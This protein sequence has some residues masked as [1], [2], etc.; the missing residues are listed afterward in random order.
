MVAIIQSKGTKGQAVG[1]FQEGE[2]GRVCDR[3]GTQDSY[4]PEYLCR[5]SGPGQ[6]SPIGLLDSHSCLDSGGLSSIF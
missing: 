3:L 1:G 4:L 2:V 6:T 5:Q